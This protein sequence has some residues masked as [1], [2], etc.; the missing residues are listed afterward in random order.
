MRNLIIFSEKPLTEI[1]S[2]G[3]LV[4]LRGDFPKKSERW[5]F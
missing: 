5:D 2:R 3:I 4:L 1:P